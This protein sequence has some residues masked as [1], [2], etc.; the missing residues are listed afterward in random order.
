MTTSAPA[1]AAGPLFDTTTPLSA[2]AAAAAGTGSKPCT[3]W[4]AAT[5]FFDIGPPMWPNPKNAT[6]DIRLTL[7]RLPRRW[8]GSVRPRLGR[9]PP[10]H[11]VGSLQKA[12]HP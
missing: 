5:R 8:R 7:L 11:F 6:V 1:T 12:V 10:H 4:P 9:S 3:V 2:A